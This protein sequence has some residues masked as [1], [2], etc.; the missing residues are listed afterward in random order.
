MPGEMCIRDRAES[1]QDAGRLRAV[2]APGRRFH[3]SA[4]RH[5]G[6]QMC[7][8]DSYRRMKMLR[9]TFTIRR[10]NAHAHV[11]A[12]LEGDGVPEG[13]GNLVFDFQAGH[14]CV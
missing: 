13:M 3:E 1:G 8:R 10:G 9:G 6:G 14:R 11:E 7:I 2:A 4:C 12:S 5:A